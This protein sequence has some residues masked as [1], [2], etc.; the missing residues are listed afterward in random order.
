MKVCGI[1]AEYNPFHLGHLRQIEYVKNVLKADKIIVVMSGNFTQRGEPAVINKYLRAK[2]AINAGADLVVELPTVF[3]VANAETF[4]T[5]AVKILLSTGVVNTICFGV[6]SG[7]KE[8]YI[9]LAKAMLNESKE[10]KATL[11]KYLETGVSLAKARFN[12]VKELNLPDADEKLISSPNNILGL[13]YVKALMKFNA[14]V[15]IEPMVRDG[16][17]NDEKLYKGITSAS[18]IRSTLKT[19]KI[20]KV[21]PCVPKFVFPD[22]SVPYDF[23]KVIL[24]SVICA[25]AEDMAEI[26]DCTEG[27]EN[28]IK[29]LLKDNPD[30]DALLNKVTT[31][32]YTESRIRRIMTANLLGINNDLLAKCLKNTLYLKVLAVKKDNELINNLSLKATA[33]VLMRKLDFKELDKTAT[34]C[35]NVDVRANDIYNLVTK[36]KN[37]EYYSLIID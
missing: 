11:K 17:H 27:L 14:Q 10:F 30:Y 33:P 4:A 16:E 18:S 9:S 1:I 19:G 34:A 22:L 20:K 25:N 32:R 2:H 12:A 15:Q 7:D 36:Q 31:K 3:S 29:A 23:T 28:R 21:K 13:E 5:G 37:N 35:F 24:S 6:E 8:S 26:P